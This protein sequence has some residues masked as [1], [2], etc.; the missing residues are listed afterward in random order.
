MN[1]AKEDSNQVLFQA[2]IESSKDGIQIADKQGQI[3][4]LNEAAQKRLGV[5]NRKLSLH[6]SDFEPL[7]RTPRI[8]EEHLTELRKHNQL[9]IRSININ[10]ED[11]RII[12]VEVTVY[13]QTIE[14]K[15]Y[16]FAV[17]RDTSNLAEQEKK[18]ALRETMLMAISSATTELLN[19]NKFFE[20]VANVLEIIGEAVQVDRTYLFTCSR[21]EQG[22]ELVSQRCEW[23]SGDA[24]PQIDNPELQNVPLD[25]FDDFIDMMRLNQPFQSIVQHLPEESALRAILESQGIISILIIPVFHNKEFW[26]FIGY[27]ECKFVRIWDEVELS[28]LQTLSNNMTAAL[29]RLDYTAKIENLAEF[30]LENPAPII[31]IDKNGAVL[32]QNKLDQLNETYFKRLGRNENL[33]LEQLLKIIIQDVVRD[34]KIKYYEVQAG[35]TQFYSITAKEIEHKSYINLYFTDI[36]K[37]K[38]TEKQLAET[39]SIVDQ[40]VQ[41]MEDVIW[42]VSYPDY[43]A[44]F[45]SPST[46][47]L[48]GIAAKEFY[49][50]S[51]VWLEP[52]IEEDKHLIQHIFDDLQTKGESDY[53]YRIELPNGDIKWVRNRTKLMYDKE[54]HEPI[55]IDGYLVDIT[56]QKLNQELTEQ[57]RF[58]AEESNSAKEEFISNMSHEIR[59]PLNAILGLS[60]QLFEQAEEGETRHTLNNIVQSGNHLQSLIENILDFSKITAGQFELYPTR[61]NL[62]SEIEAVHQMLEGL[63]KEKQLEYKLIIDTALDQFIQIDKRRLKQV[64][65][66]ILSNSLKFTDEGFVR[67][68]AH[69]S[70]CKSRVEITI[71][72]SGS[73]MSSSFIER[74]FDKFAQEDASPE[75]RAQG[76]G[77]GMA[78]SKKIMDLLDGEIQVKSSKGFGTEVMLTLPFMPCTEAEESNTNLF[79]DLSLLKGK[80][81]LVVEDNA[82]NALIVRNTLDKFGII[83]H[84]SINGREAIDFLKRQQ[85]DLILMDLQMPVMGG[86]MATSIIRQQLKSNIPIVGLSANALTSS[87]TECLAAGMNDYITKPFEEERILEVLTSLLLMP[88][89]E[90]K[91]YDLSRYDNSQDRNS[92]HLKEIV[93]LFIQLIPEQLAEMKTA[94]LEKQYQEI[95]RVAHK[96]LPNFLMFGV[97]MGVENIKFLNHFDE[98]DEHQVAE[99]ENKIVQLEES[100]REVIEEMKRDYMN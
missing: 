87:R 67:L 62:K 18:L 9:V 8:W 95:K 65:I 35:T 30:P 20:A 83:M 26:G 43:K 46:E 91:L 1:R 63:A 12:P 78:I 70:S 51:Q 21:D 55:R 40:I 76:S 38:E 77:L 60:R 33:S 58:L 74:I 89:Q 99:L 19:N 17:T 42:S 36:S 84:H 100:V 81:I 88:K 96:I 15:E 64:I 59:T 53:N 3:V 27:D 45:I 66:N 32:F 79:T 11:A 86:I 49:R 57:A 61:T 13:I 93:A 14:E 52:I 28:I 25:L 7:F 75:R 23:N 82:L 92:A 6:V 50:N 54:T 56:D 68:E 97:N 90:E 10:Q 47:K 24:A 22:S 94:A 72:D 2:F 5:Q 29:D 41:N 39:R 37:L 71:K 85:V 16:V 34:E 4:Y 44:L 69:L 31:R 80:E 48:Y 73:G 98:S